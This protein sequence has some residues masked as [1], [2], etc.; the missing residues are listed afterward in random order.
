MQR[1]ILF[2]SNDEYGLGRMFYMIYKRKIRYVHF[3]FFLAPAS[4]ACNSETGVLEPVSVRRSKDI[5]TFARFSSM[6]SKYHS[7]NFFTMVLVFVL[8]Q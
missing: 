1:F 6:Y 5:Y 2:A 8:Y 4:R 3:S 7:L